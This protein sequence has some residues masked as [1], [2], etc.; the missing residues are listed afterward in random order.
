MSNKVNRIYVFGEFRFDSKSR[1]L[2]RLDDETMLSPKA[3]ALLTLLLENAGQYVSKERIFE[4]IWPDTFVED[5]VLTQN[6]YS[7]RKVIDPG[8]PDVKAI[9]NRTRL[10]YRFNLPVAIEEKPPREPTKIRTHAENRA[11]RT[12]WGMLLLILSFGGVLVGVVSYRRY[13]AA[14]LSQPV[15]LLFRPV[16]TSGD[17]TTPA[18]SPDGEFAAFARDKSLYLR[19]LRSNKEIRLETPGVHAFS[20]LQFSS[21]GAS[22]LFRPQ[23]VMRTDANI[24]QTSR[25]GGEVKLVAEKTWGSFGLSNDGKSVA[26]GRNH[27]SETAQTLVVRNLSNGEEK[28]IAR[29]QFPEIFLHNCSPVFS[30]DDKRLAFVAQ[31]YM[32]RQTALYVIDLETGGRSEIRPTNLRQFE[33]IGFASDGTTIIASASEGGRFYHLWKITPGQSLA[34]RLTNGLT[35]FGEISFSRNGTMIALQTTENPRIHLAA[36]SDIS[37]NQPLASER[38]DFTGQTGLEWIDEENLVYSAYSAD[39]PMSNLLRTNITTQQTTT[40]TSNTDFHSDA[41][42]ATLDGRRIFFTS[43]E[44]AFL[45][46]RGIDGSGGGRYDVT[47]G[48]D[49]YRIFP[50][51]TQDGGYLYYIFR[52]L[53]GGE[54]IR[55]NLADGTESVLLPRTAANPVGKLA[56]GGDGRY[57]AFINWGDAVRTENDEATFRLGV[58]AT[59]QPDSLR[60]FDVKLLIAAVQLAPDNSGIDYVSF[61]GNASLLIRQPFDN[62]AAK[63]LLRLPNRR[64]YNFAW[65]KGGGRIALSHG[66]QQR[67]AVLISGF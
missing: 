23:M 7:L 61:D 9:E 4:T 5:G 20:S 67:D 30:P 12:I 25:L 55:R 44:T 64:L 41:P 45:N 53:G 8:S 40:L 26:F 48:T 42:T 29:I 18:I 62:G 32:A 15:T 51:V 43:S 31:N 38:S 47:S 37:A 28:T 36:A 59:D 17:I 52:T 3:A 10:G 49:G 46:I 6:V 33:Q 58:F 57:L 2:R 27:P 66:I 34:E 39:N 16:T 50:Q 54:I 56:L 35:N 63:E 13:A 22:L 14:P 19:D 24:L 1:R 11:R 65:S 60:F 21:D